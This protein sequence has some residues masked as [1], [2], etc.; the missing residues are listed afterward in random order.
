M[1]LISTIGAGLMGVA[2]LL[3]VANLAWSLW[4]GPVAGDNPWG[5]WTL[6]WATTSPPP[7]H[8]FDALPEIRSRRPL[9]DEGHPAAPDPVVGQDTEAPPPQR[10]KVA[11]WCLIASEAGFFGVLLLVYAFLN[12]RAPL[13]PNARNS[14]DLA[15]TAVFS[16]CLFASSFTLWRSERAE[17]NG[18]RGG[19]IAWLAATLALGAV[20]L[21]GQ[22]SEYWGLYR[23]G[24][25]VDANLFSSTFYLLTGFHGFHVGLGLLALA[26]MLLRACAGDFVPGSKS[27]L[28]AVG[29][30]WHFVDVVWIFVFSLVY[31]LPRVA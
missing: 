30:Y 1:N 16:G 22:G 11:V 18:R 2:A 7:V 27:P 4:R 24:V 17:A 13:G 26:V 5:G 21:A 28:A 9:W 12:V 6:E 20:F 19:M 31:L 23:H 29:L 14:L 10:S 25:T 15:R 8:N 3:L